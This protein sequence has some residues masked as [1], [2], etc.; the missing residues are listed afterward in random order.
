[1]HFGKHGDIILTKREFA[2]TIVAMNV[3]HNFLKEN[4]QLNDATIKVYAKLKNT[5][6]KEFDLADI[7]YELVLKQPI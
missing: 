7:F 5:N 1:M 3:R 2:E 6:Q 4:K